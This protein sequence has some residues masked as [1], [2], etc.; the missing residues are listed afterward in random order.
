MPLPLCVQ[1]SFVVGFESKA[2]GTQKQSTQKG[3]E[4]TIQ[5]D[6]F[7]ERIKDVESLLEPDPSNILLHIEMWMNQ[8]VVAMQQRQSADGDLGQ[9]RHPFI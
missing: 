3:S 8:L 1:F 4:K 7:A 2:K 6:M 9:L 5:L